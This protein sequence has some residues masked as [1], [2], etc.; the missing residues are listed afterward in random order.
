MGPDV[1]TAARPLSLQLHEQVLP[2]LS[3]HAG[4]LAASAIMVAIDP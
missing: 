3:C 4:W 1:L 2:A